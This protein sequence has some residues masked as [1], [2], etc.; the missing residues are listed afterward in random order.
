MS[1][2]VVSNWW[3][4]PTVQLSNQI[5]ILWDLSVSVKIKS[6]F[7]LNEIWDI[8]EAHHNFYGKW[9]KFTC[10]NL[11]LVIL[12]WNKIPAQAINKR[13]FFY[14]VDLETRGKMSN[15]RVYFWPLSLTRMHCLNWPLSKYL[16][17]HAL[18][19]QWKIHQKKFAQKLHS[20]I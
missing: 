5:F 12:G 16:Q 20:H 2:V 4:H 11:L 15:I 13:W 14:R 18:I 17:E 1:E 3:S 9:K 10:C 8:G 19:C 7:K 6:M